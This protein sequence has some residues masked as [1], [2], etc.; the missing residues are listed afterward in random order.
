VGGRVNLTKMPR[1]S[2]NMESSY[3]AAEGK[4]PGSMT[5]DSNFFSVKIFPLIP[6]K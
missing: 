5:M 4:R 1:A 6:Q 3:K 2:M